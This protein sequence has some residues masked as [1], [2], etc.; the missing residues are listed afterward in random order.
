MNVVLWIVQIFLAVAF[1]LAGVMKSTQPKEKLQPNLPWVEDF[2]LGPVRLIGVAELLGGL[3]LILPATTGIA[4]VLTPIAA[5]LDAGAAGFLA[6]LDR[7]MGEGIMSATGDDLVR[8][9]GHPTMSLAEGL[10]QAG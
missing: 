6:A 5:G 1:V 7:S 2:S 9:I 4:P 10:R 3:G 8:L